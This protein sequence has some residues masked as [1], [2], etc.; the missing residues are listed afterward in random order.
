MFT[1]IIVIIFIVSF[2]LSLLSMKDLGFAEE[3]KKIL[4][5]KRIRGTIVFFKNKIIHYPAK[6][7]H[8]SKSSF[9]SSKVDSG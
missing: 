2:V 7:D 3:L 4:D 1:I 5:R 9:S 8:S 6:R